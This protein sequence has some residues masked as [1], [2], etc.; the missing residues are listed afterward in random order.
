MQ[1][2]LVRHTSVNVPKG[3]CYGH[4]EVPLASSYTKEKSIV[5]KLIENISF[6]KVYSSPLSRCLKLATC[7]SSSVLTDSRLIEMNFGEWELKNWSDIK[8]DYAD[9]WMNDY[10]NLACPGGES[11]NDLLTRLKF[12]LGD[13][14]KINKNSIIIT[15]SGII[16]CAY[17]LIQNID[18]NKLFDLKVDFGS[19]HSFE[20]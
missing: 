18:I 1:L 4:S 5:L 8:D 13:I 14:N 20:L 15:H 12:F 19:I 10:L 3:M 9:Q 6:E 7:I 2:H 17:H 16:R 11:F